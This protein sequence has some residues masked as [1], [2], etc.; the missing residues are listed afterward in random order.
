MPKGK[1]LHR[2]DHPKTSKS[3]RTVAVPGFTAESLRQRLATLGPVDDPEQLV[4]ATRN[5]T[6]L[7]TNN[8]RRR[9]RQIMKEADVGGVTPH[10]F[11]RKVVT[12]LNRA[13]GAELAAE[14]LGHTSPDI[15]R[16]H[17][18]EQ[19]D[20]VNPAAADILEQQLGS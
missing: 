2:Q 3:R 17:Y 18:I 8:V 6:A 7:T 19:D 16:A 1:Q 10:A 4:F 15:T 13:A 5:G 20:Q 14:A 12:I 11:R 9:L